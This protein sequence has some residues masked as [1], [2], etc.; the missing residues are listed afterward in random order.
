LSN[1]DNSGTSFYVALAF[2]PSFED[3]RQNADGTFPR[4]GFNASNPL[5]TA[6]LMQN[7]EDVWRFVTGTELTWN[8][9]SSEKSS[10]RASAMGGADFFTQKNALFFPPELQFEPQDGLPGTSLLSKSD[11]LNLNLGT[12]LV[13]T[14]NGSSFRATTSAGIQ[15]ARRD[16][17]I[18]RITSRNLIA[19]QPNVNSGTNVQVN[20]LRQLI[21]YLGGF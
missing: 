12:N 2:T 16:L 4:N 5:E 8:I 19:G 11:N 17:D 7:D 18:G 3:L 21:V 20:Q 13:H 14:Y 10:L 15:Y 6:A 9:A 1:N